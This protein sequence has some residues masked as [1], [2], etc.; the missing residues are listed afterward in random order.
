MLHPV[1]GV[2]II[3]SGEALLPSHSNHFQILRFILRNAV[4]SAI[5]L[6]PQKPSGVQ[7]AITIRPPVLHTRVSSAATLIVACHTNSLKAGFEGLHLRGQRVHDDLLPAALFLSRVVFWIDIVNPP[8]PHAV[9]LHN[10][11]ILRPGK[12][13]SLQRHHC[14]TACNKR[15][16]FRFIQLVSNTHVERAREQV[17]GSLREVLNEI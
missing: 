10:G 6:R 16:R 14:D 12:V 2:V 11:L 7:S 9:N 15:I 4:G 1:V 13:C 5:V 8:R 17:S 3:T